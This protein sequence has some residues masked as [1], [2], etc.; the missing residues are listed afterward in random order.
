MERVSRPGG[1]ILFYDEQLH[2]SASLLEK[3]YFRLVISRH[4]TIHS[5]P[6]HLI[7]PG[8]ERVHV[9]QVYRFYY[10]CTAYQ[11][12]PSRPASMRALD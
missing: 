2:A 7:P 10:L 8:L 6:V 4:N 5:C 12:A 3:L 9:S 11:S 1:L